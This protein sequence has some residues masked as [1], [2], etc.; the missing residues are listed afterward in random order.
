MA[1]V[2]RAT[3]EVS[4]EPQHQHIDHTVSLSL[5]LSAGTICLHLFRIHPGYLDNSTVN[6]KH[7]SSVR[8]TRPR[9]RLCDNDNAK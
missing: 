6:W 3:M 8:P 9:Y 2:V 5:E 7:I 4:L 1:K